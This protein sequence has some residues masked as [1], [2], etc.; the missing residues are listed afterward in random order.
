[1]AE[2]RLLRLHR[3]YLTR[4]FRESKYAPS[5]DR[6]VQSARECFTHLSS[7]KPPDL[8]WLAGQILRLLGIAG[9]RCPDLLR[10]WIVIFY[11]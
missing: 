2:T 4:G 3:P 10:F 5:K 11:S 8:L 9:E 1:M 6:C 7:D